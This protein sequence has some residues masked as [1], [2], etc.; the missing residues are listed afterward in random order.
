MVFML[1]HWCGRDGGA[2]G[3][4]ELAAGGSAAAGEFG[5]ELS[6]SSDEG[7]AR[8]REKNPIVFIVN[9]RV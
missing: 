8:L 5:S 7:G 3:T 2:A 6:T 9:Q 4:R 1:R